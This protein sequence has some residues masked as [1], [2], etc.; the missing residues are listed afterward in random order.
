MSVRTPRALRRRQKPTTASL[1]PPY[2]DATAG[3]TC[4]TRTSPGRTRSSRKALAQ[5]PDHS[6][7]GTARSGSRR[8]RAPGPPR[9]AR[10]VGSRDSSRSAIVAAQRR[11][12]SSGSTKTPVLPF[13]DDFRR[14]VVHRPET[15]EAVR[16]RLQVDQAEPFAA[17]RQRR[18]ARPL[19]IRPPA[20][21]AAG[22]PRSAR[23]RPAP[24]SAASRCRRG[25]SSPSP[26]ITSRAAGTRATTPGQARMQLFVPLVPFCGA[27]RPTTSTVELVARGDGRSRTSTRLWAA[28]SGQ[29]DDL[30]DAR[31][32]RRRRPRR[33]VRVCDPEIAGVR[34]TSPLS[35]A[36]RLHASM[37]CRNTAY[38]VRSPRRH[39]RL[40]MRARPR[41]ENRIHG[42]GA[43]KR[44]RRAPRRTG[45][46]R[47]HAAIAWPL[48]SSVTPRPAGHVSCI[49]S[50]S[51]SDT[52]PIPPPRSPS[53]GAASNAS[54]W[55]VRAHGSALPSAPAVSALGEAIRS[56]A[57]QP[58]ELRPEHEQQDASVTAAFRL[59]A[60]NPLMN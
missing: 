6:I 49:E 58:P 33:E 11:S 8:R 25:A 1:G 10:A 24:L 30:A 54:A 12:T 32:G 41:C 53:S 42:G 4:R 18:T 51:S 2:R 44:V 22:S 16:H 31:V 19:R 13:V 40:S 7:A 38:G 35:S 21:A 37:P 3:I 55:R 43:S 60:A 36:E 56:V 48:R 45:A 47:R 17:A 15:R 28:R 27:S 39:V 59:S 20:P 57:D 52:R 26:T 29:T 23:L 46:C 50:Q 34:A 9:P 14:G 5:Q